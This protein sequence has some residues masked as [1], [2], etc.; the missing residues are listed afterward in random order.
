MSIDIFTDK[1]KSVFDNIDS[2]LI[3][4]ETNFREL[5]NWS[6]INTMILMAVLET[7]FNYSITTEELK[8]CETIVD[9]YNLLSK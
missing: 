6:S 4:P 2:N 7:D 3:K 8:K 1:L 9:L 5:E